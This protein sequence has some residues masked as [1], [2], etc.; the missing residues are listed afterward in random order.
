MAHDASPSW[1]GFNYQGKVAVYYALSFI[2]EKLNLNPSF[3]FSDYC[4]L[5]ENNEDFE[6]QFNGAF[7]SFHQVKAYDKKSFSSYSSALFGLSLNLY[8]N[9]EPTGYIHTWKAIN[10]NK[11]KTL[12]ESISGTIAEILDEYA[13]NAGEGVLYSA[14]ADGVKRGKPARII[15]QI[16]PDK[17]IAEVVGVLKGIVT[18]KSDA[19]SRINSYV[20]PDG[21][22]YCD[23]NGINK[24]LKDELS[25][26]FK[27]KKNINTAKQIDNAFYY[28]LGKIDRYVIE[29][30]GAKALS[31]KL[32]SITFD[33][34]V[35]ILES[36]FE[37]VSEAYL[38]AKF[39]ERFIV[40]YQEY[41]ENP[42][43]YSVPDDLEGFVCNLTEVM[44][45][46]TCVSS[47]DLWR[48]YKNFSPNIEFQS[49][50]VLN[51][52]ISINEP[53]VRDV[54]LKVFHELDYES[55]INLDDKKKLFYRS[56][57]HPEN[58]YLPTTI[59]DKSHYQIAKNIY[60]NDG[61]IETLYEVNNLV[62]GGE[63]VESLARKL[64]MHTI[65]PE[66]EGGSTKEPREE[67]FSKLRL[68]PIG[69]AKD[70]IN[71]D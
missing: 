40:L 47:E 6:I 23:L 48:Y 68:I 64:N 41:V 51:Q 20:Y 32:V 43:C 33:D 34:I 15:R 38:A 12:R 3:D 4:L 67:F 18:G 52:A 44:N 42:D 27:L 66:E 29:R 45:K 49:G 25:K 60:E 37:D 19:L 54:L 63:Q 39:K 69:T 35:G 46:L 53:A 13:L 24:M 17:N 26:S 7:I 1:S 5:L 36:D 10:S 30:H 14:F 21:N 50:S 8:L 62:Y 16:L 11:G 28:V 70:E 22:N 61:M 56:K 57:K 59:N 2:N 58:F 9:P 65:P 71:A 55:C 31:E